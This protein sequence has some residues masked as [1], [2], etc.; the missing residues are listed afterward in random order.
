[1]QDFGAFDNAV[2]EETLNEFLKLWRARA[3]VP[4]ASEDCQWTLE[5]EY[6]R[7]LDIIEIFSLRK[8][9]H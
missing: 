7:K 1:M 4:Y 3:K 5:F 2:E 8:L 6:S 9:D